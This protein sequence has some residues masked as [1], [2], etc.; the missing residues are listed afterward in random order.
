MI[1]TRV[2]SACDDGKTC[3]ALHQTDRDTVVV[4][5][6]A[7]IDSGVLAQLGLPAGT[8]AVEVPAA[9]LAEALDSWPALRQTGRGTVIVPGNAVTDPEALRQLCLPAGE[10]AV[11]VPADLLAGVL[12]AC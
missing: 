5:G 1:V 4:Q 6:W 12:Q 2:R 11:E 10:R 3:P 9:L 7:V 8:D